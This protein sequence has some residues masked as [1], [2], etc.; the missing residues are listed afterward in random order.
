MVDELF[1]GPVYRFAMAAALVTFMLVV[2][3]VLV[4]LAA[5]RAGGAQQPNTARLLLRVGR[6]LGLFIVA[7]SLV[8]GGTKGLDW[9]A[10]VLWLL[11][12]GSLAAVLFV[13]SAQL[14]VRLLLRSRL[15]AEIERGNPAAGLA[16]AAHYV[17]TAFIVG[18][19]VGG[20]GLAM[21]GVSL[22]FFAI[23]QLTLHA[24]VLLFRALTAYDDAEEV[25]SENVAA[26]LSYAGVTIGL[27]M[28]IGRAAE[29]SFEGWVALFK[30]FGPALLY[31]FSLYVVRQ[32]VVQTLVLGAPLRLWKGAL[33]VAIGEQRNLGIGALE[34][35]AYLGTAMLLGHVS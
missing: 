24:F 4:G 1:S 35:A 19:S 11:S 33:D 25:L 16:A 22:A 6:I 29:G 3:R 32:F 27:G 18:A 21:M 31:C 15:W 10:D 17:A 28:I 14:G 34:A 2:E 13:V 5:R 26:A 9:Q 7:G 12:F 8:S 30:G 23:A 20:E